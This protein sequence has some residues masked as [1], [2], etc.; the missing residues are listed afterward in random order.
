MASTNFERSQ[1]LETPGRTITT[2][3]CRASTYIPVILER[4]DAG[5]PSL[6]GEQRGKDNEQSVGH[7][8]NAHPHFPLYLSPIVLF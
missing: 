8:K 3:A 2:R 1:Q 4:K 6:V 7:S 5:M